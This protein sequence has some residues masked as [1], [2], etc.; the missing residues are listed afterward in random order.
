MNL[1]ASVPNLWSAFNSDQLSCLNRSD[2]ATLHQ[3]LLMRRSPPSTTWTIHHF[4]LTLASLEISSLS[5]DPGGGERG[6]VAQSLSLDFVK[7]ITPPDNLTEHDHYFPF[8]IISAQP[9]TLSTGSRVT[10]RPSSLVPIIY[11]VARSSEERDQW[12]N[13]LKLVI[14]QRDREGSEVTKERISEPLEGSSK[15]ALDSSPPSLESTPLSIEPSKIIEGLEERIIQRLDS[16]ANVLLA[17]HHSSSS[18]DWKLLL[19]RDGLRCSRLISSSLLPMAG[20]TTCDIGDGGVMSVRGE[21]F[22][23]FSIPEIFAALLNRQ[24]RC[25]IQ[26]DIDAYPP[27]KWLSSHT[28]VEYIRYKPIWPTQPRDYCTLLHWRL[29]TDGSFLFYAISESSTHYPIQSHL[30][31]GVLHVG[32]YV[33]KHVAGGTEVSLIVQVDVGGNIP[34]S[35]ANLVIA[36]R[37]MMLLTLRKALIQ[38]WTGKARPDLQT[39]GPPSYEGQFMTT[40]HSHPFL[41]LPIPHFLRSPEL[42]QISTQSELNSSLKILS[43]RD[44]SSDCPHTPSSEASLSSPPSRRQLSA[45]SYI[46]DGLLSKR[47]D[48]LKQWNLRYFTLDDSFLHYYHHAD[49]PL[50]RRS[51]QIISRVTVQSIPFESALSGNEGGYQFLVSLPESSLEYHLSASSEGDRESWIRSLRKLIEASEQKEQADQ[52]ERKGEQQ[53]SLPYQNE[54]RKRAL[55]VGVD[56][57]PPAPEN[58]GDEESFMPLD[59]IQL[60]DNCSTELIE[61]LTTRWRQLTSLLST[62]RPLNWNYTFDS[63]TIFGSCD[64]SPTSSSGGGELFA[65]CSLRVERILP[66]RLPEIF[67]I[68]IQPI[69][70]R[71]FL[72]KSSTEETVKSIERISFVNKYCWCESHL[73][74]SP[75]SSEPLSER[76]RRKLVTWSVLENGVLMYHTESQPDLLKIPLVEPSSKD[77]VGDAKFPFDG[78]LFKEMKN[79][80]RITAYTTI[81]SPRGDTTGER[82]EKKKADMFKKKEQE[83]DALV[84]V[85]EKLYGKRDKLPDTPG[86]SS[87]RGTLAGLTDSCPL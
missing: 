48:H 42:V 32:G 24:L 8:Q 14:S 71:V 62:K 56:K 77:I 11:L 35:I 60:H 61:H 43:Q 50:P 22:Y 66:Y 69:H 85:L 3:G 29:L 34:K 55:D 53:Q 36:K 83:I 44:I 37:P 20:I 13:K 79:G 73:L 76:D 31:R 54:G 18:P 4:A 21:I 7:I 2:P 47:S 59:L 6:G 75:S 49:D 9:T 19:E 87:P 81:D 51:L 16:A 26:P 38:L 30:T 39:H 74:H 45:Y 70:H 23:P 80:V 63:E 58:A 17:S 12:V 65:E 72:Q 5:S 33:M 84:G 78:Y 10:R 64:A 68:F 15:V 82:K 41:P 67:A 1:S 52:D 57:R 28:G 86:L 46:K 25:Q 27:I 40:S